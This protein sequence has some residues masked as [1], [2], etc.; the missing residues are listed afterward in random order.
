[1][2]EK[3]YTIS[4]FVNNI[5]LTKEDNIMTTLNTKQARE[6]GYKILSKN[7]PRLNFKQAHA[8]GYEIK[9]R[10]RKWSISFLTD[11]A[12]EGVTIELYLFSYKTRKA[13]LQAITDHIT[14]FKTNFDLEKW[15]AFHP[16][17]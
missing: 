15:M 16:N 1:M 8:L 7:R 5:S 14:I 10:F 2:K 17:G 11:E 6:L 3:L 12:G 9:Q 13:A 4:R